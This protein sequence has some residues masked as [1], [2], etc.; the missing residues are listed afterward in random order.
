MEFD[1]QEEEMEIPKTQTQHQRVMAHLV[2]LLH[3]QNSPS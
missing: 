1:E 3:V 2:T